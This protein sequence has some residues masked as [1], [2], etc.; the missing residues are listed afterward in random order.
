MG[1]TNYPDCQLLMEVPLQPRLDKD[2]ILLIQINSN[3]PFYIFF[4]TLMLD[5][6]SGR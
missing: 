5:A 2:V 4:S 3:M 1:Y 6:L